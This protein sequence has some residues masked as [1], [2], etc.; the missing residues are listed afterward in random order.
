[1]SEETIEIGIKNVHTIKLL[2]DALSK[3]SDTMVFEIKRVVYSDGEG[4]ID[5]TFEQYDSSGKI[6]SMVKFDSSSFICFNVFTDKRFEVNI[7]GLMKLFDQYDLDEIYIFEIFIRCKSDM[8]GFGLRLNDMTIAMHETKMLNKNDSKDNFSSLEPEF[9]VTIDS[10]RFYKVIENYQ[11]FSKEIGIKFDKELFV[12]SCYYDNNKYV[13]IIK[14]K[15]TKRKKDSICEVKNP[16][17]CF[18][19]N[20]DFSDII[21]IFNKKLTT[22][23]SRPIMALYQ[24]LKIYSCQNNILVLKYSLG[25]L[26]S[27]SLVIYPIKSEF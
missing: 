4:D 10:C 11:K 7:K 22:L 3:M 17:F 13:T 16:P 27:L 25:E 2:F 24:N 14:T 12:T 23:T 8:I 1:M 20:M 5:I 9:L 26:G 19:N 18:N 15:E 21:S 6:L